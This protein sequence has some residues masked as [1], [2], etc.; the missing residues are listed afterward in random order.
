MYDATTDLPL[1]LL[2]VALL[3]GDLSLG[4]VR[5]ATSC[6]LHLPRE[7]T[8]PTDVSPA[9]LLSLCPRREPAS[10][11]S[12]TPLSTWPAG[13]V[14]RSAS[15][16]TPESNVR[17]PSSTPRRWRRFLAGPLSGEHCCSSASI[18]VVRVDNVQQP[19][20]HLHF[21]LPL[22]GIGCAGRHCGAETLVLGLGALQLRL[23]S[24]NLST[25]VFIRNNNNSNIRFKSDCL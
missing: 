2:G 15:S 10:S 3:L 12:A 4:G 25:S 11:F 7:R 5:N 24:P 13:N 1:R 21:S 22:L 23:Q 17:P 18:P 16:S 8:G 14:M 20:P 19:A 9:A 6:T